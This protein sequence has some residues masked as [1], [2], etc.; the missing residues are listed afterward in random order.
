MRLKT[1]EMQGFKSFPEK[2]VLSFDHGVTAVVGPNGS[3]KSNISDAMRWVLGEI[4]SKSIRGTKMEDVIFGGTDN[5]RP[6]A[7]CEVSLTIDN[8]DPENRMAI[9]Y[10]EVTVTRRYYRSGDSEYFINR[11]PVRLRDITELFMNTG[12]GRSGYS[13]V[14][15]GKAAEIISQKSDERR[16]I[17]EEAAGI[18]K[19]R[20]K[21]ND[22]EKKLNEVEDNLVRIGDI[23]GELEKRVGPLE[24]ES[25]K[26]RKYLDLYEKKKNSEVALSIFDISDIKNKKEK[27]DFE[28]NISSRELEA[29]NEEISSLENK[30]ERLYEQV[31][32]DKLRYEELNRL[33]REA[34]EE[35]F[36]YESAGKVF[37]N[38]IRHIKEI[39]VSNEERL[40]ILAEELTS[41]QVKAESL[42][43]DYENKKDL[44]VSTVSENE[45]NTAKIAETDKKID[46][47][48]DEID[49]LSDS[50]S[51]AG[52]ELIN[53]KI[54][55]STL[56]VSDRSGDEK[57]A[58]LINESNEL[59]QSHKRLL[60]R[61]AQ[62]DE[63]ITSYNESINSVNKTI[64]NLKNEEQNISEKVAALSE[65]LNTI[66]V[67]LHS[68]EHRVETLERMEAQLD[69]YS[70]SVRRVMNAVSENKLNGI[71]GPVSKIITTDPKH[72]AAIES[73]LGASMQNIV[74]ETE[75]DAK[76][77][78]H[79]LRDNKAGRATFYPVSTIKPSYFNLKEF[80]FTG[81]KGYV[82]VAHDLAECND[83]FRG[84]VD[85]LLCR[86]VV[87]D[88]LDNATAMA[89]D[90]G[91]K[92]R[93]VTID[94]Q[95][96]NTGGS[97]TG[98]SAVRESGMLTRQNDITKLNKEIVNCKDELVRV[99]KERANAEKMLRDKQNELAD[100]SARVALFNSLV[101][102]ENAQKKMLELQAQSDADRLKTLS[103]A[104]AGIDE[105]IDRAK[106]ARIE[107]KER[108]VKLTEEIDKYNK[109]QEE[110]ISVRREL[111]V[112][113]DELRKL[114][115]TLLIKI[116]EQ[117]KDVEAAEASLA[118]VN[119]QIASLESNIN[120]AN[121]A[122]SESDVRLA[123]FTAKIETGEG[124]AKHIAEKI[125]VYEKEISEISAR[126]LENEKIDSDL[127]EEQKS[128]THRR[129]MLFRQHTKLESDIASIA[130]EQQKLTDTLWEE[131]E[132][133]YSSALELNLPP[134]TAENRKIVHATV[135]ELRTK[136]RQMGS[137]N[138]NSIE[139]YNDVKT[140]YDFMKVQYDDLTGSRSELG[141]VIFKL[142]KE[143]RERF[144][145]VFE[146]INANFKVVFTELFGGGSANI[147]LTDPDN[148]L[149]SGIEIEVA[150]PGKIIKNLSLL[151]GGEQSF[152]AIALF[153]AILKVNPTPFCVLDEIEAALDEVNVARFAEYCRKYSERTQ[154]ICITHRRGTMESAD[155]LY[156]VT[157]YER[158]VSK[159]L[160]VNVNEVENKIGVKL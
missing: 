116:A 8:T 78:I 39:R 139:E 134:V 38:E 22:A 156:G 79:F 122:I 109:L 142:E 42:V 138:V 64:E 121:Q 5:R 31:Q 75:A 34:N 100:T 149:T 132:L 61:I 2:T 136:I 127:K 73:A 19:Y 70:H 150:P 35:R 26:A 41:A 29:A 52:D 158:G 32:R 108:I 60:D 53:A 49:S 159:V 118:L 105:D 21:K 18:A 55:L 141:G 119:N 104:I 94:G 155:M 84:I 65:A 92:I 9:E 137:V 44:L 93:C 25:E 151:S 110:K 114:A 51:D 115:N 77:A 43:L 14:S 128:L 152:V 126:N 97:F 59:S 124:A 28:F 129:D 160:S 36:S 82:A 74:V 54:E 144:K 103:D 71:H 86:T 81:Y 154:F 10:D 147:S 47:I 66:T 23:L 143:M 120:A 157:M 113:Q 12:I 145:G 88:T 72:S 69:G 112:A 76:K 7:F 27:L 87:F 135:S 33:T 17:F 102:A 37:E 15:Q 101:S 45:E 68:K 4:S 62:A 13:I 57:R 96:I 131:Y 11:K 85:Y 148:V 50:V 133:T 125:D 80:D 107:V 67:E 1:L 91:F 117:R 153:F 106:Q 89:R 90:C 95:L 123:E 56:E 48:S 146:A 130:N 40:K 83:K 58:D 24:K 111:S 98:G 30:A 99:T 140:R 3:G 16:I 46:L 20:H 63:T 6:M